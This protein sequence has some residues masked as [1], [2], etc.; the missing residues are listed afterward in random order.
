MKARQDMS[1]TF[2][3]D[4][5]SAQDGCRYTGNFTIKK[6]GIRDIAALGVR[7]A[8]LNGGMYHDPENPGRGVDE[9]TDDFNNMIA[10]FELSIK[11]APKWWNLDEITDVDLMGHVFKEVIS[12]ERSFLDRKRDSKSGTEK[13]GANSEGNRAPGVQETNVGRGVGKVVGE[14]VQASLEP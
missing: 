14:E 8:Q 5:T 12:F 13:S 1:K 9:S 2:S 6:L 4:Y 3:V 10:H 11:D 7:K